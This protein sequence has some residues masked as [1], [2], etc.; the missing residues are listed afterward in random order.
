MKWYQY[1][2]IQALDYAT[3]VGA[4]TDAAPDMEQAFVALAA[5]P[6]VGLC[7]K[8]IT[9][10]PGESDNFEVT[11]DLNEADGD[12]RCGMDVVSYPKDK[13]SCLLDYNSVIQQFNHETELNDLKTIICLRK[14][15]ASV[16]R[17]SVCNVSRNWWSMAYTACHAPAPLAS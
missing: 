14:A 3:W 6:A 10:G 7:G 8:A 1:N 5:T 11:I 16:D 13:Y 15:K 9:A 2:Y 4:G 12:T 17:I